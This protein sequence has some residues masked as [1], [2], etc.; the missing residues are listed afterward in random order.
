VIH[1]IDFLVLETT[2]MPP[3]RAAAT[4]SIRITSLRARL[5][6]AGPKRSVDVGNYADDALFVLDGF[7]GPEGGGVDDAPSFRWTGDEAFIEVPAA[8]SISFVVGGGRPVGVPPARVSLW[9]DNEPL[10]ED[11]TLPDEATRITLRNPNPS[12]SGR[13]TVRLRSTVFN[14]RRAGLSDDGRDLGL[15]L[16][17][18]DFGERG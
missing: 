3:P 4:R 9:I 14:P 12:N 16:Y 17:R 8:A 7:H 2:D 5:R 13:V 10:V 6:Q 15:R 18:V 1:D 11:R